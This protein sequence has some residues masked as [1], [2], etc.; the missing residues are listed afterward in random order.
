METVEPWLINQVLTI[1]KHITNIWI[2]SL[3][4]SFNH[5]LIALQQYTHFLQWYS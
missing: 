3:C 4:H 5:C 2:C 1:L